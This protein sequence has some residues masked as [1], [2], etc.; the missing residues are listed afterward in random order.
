MQTNKSRP[1]SRKPVAVLIGVARIA[2]VVSCA[3]SAIACTCALPAYQPEPLT[4]LVDKYGPSAVEWSLL[5]RFADRS[6]LL[7]TR[8]H[9]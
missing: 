5:P 7:P 8:I 9:S 2:L 4:E 6:A 3:V 1:L